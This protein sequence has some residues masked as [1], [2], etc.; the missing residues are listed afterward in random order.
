MPGLI[1]CHV[2]SFSRGQHPGARGGAAHA[3]DGAGGALMRAMLDR[4]FTTVRDTGGA[5]WGI[6]KASSAGYSRARG[7]S[8]RA[9]RSVRPAATATRAGGPTRRR[10]ARLQNARR[11]PRPSPTAW[12]EVRRAVR[13]QLRQG[14][15]HIKIMVSGGVASPYDPLESLQYR[16][17][18]SAP[19]SRRRR[20]SGA[21]LR[22]RLLGQGD[23]ARGRVR[24]ARHRAR[25]PDRRPPRSSW[26]S[27]AR[28]WCRHWSPTT[29][30]RHAADFGMGAGEPREEQGRAGGRSPLARARESAGVA[31]GVRSRTSSASSSPTSPRSS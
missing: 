28:T 8:S 22:P 19:R 10:R 7:C 4:G 6:R 9:R 12:T 5:D 29:R 31:H 21:S 24:R 17:T 11:S 26:P 20:R 1:D 25:E 14:A 15:D 16:R 13:E 2:Q 18:R 30:S 23:R 27:A 3:A